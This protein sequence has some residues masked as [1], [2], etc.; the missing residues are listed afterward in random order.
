M[1]GVEI[2]YVC[3]ECHTV[4]EDPKS[5]VETHGLDC[6]PYEQWSG[7]PHCGSAYTE[8]HR[9]SCCTEW[10]DGDYIKINDNRYCENCYDKYEL[11]EE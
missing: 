5:W 2:M 3:L 10:I 11:G 7:C 9:C 8:A 6:G 4:F 1:I